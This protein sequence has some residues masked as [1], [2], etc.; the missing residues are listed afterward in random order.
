M[1]GCGMM[2]SMKIKEIADQIVV[3][4][5]T[6]GLARRF[7]PHPALFS[8][9]RTELGLL[10]AIVQAFTHAM[11]NARDQFSFRDRIEAQLAGNHYTW[12]DTL[13]VA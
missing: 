11:L 8:S 4:G 12:R 1:I 10:C 9:S 6:L 13:Q 3:S 7:E 5:E 2:F